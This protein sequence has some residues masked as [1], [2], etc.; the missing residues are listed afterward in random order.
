VVFAD[1][2]ALREYVCVGVLMMMVGRQAELRRWWMLLESGQV[3]SGG[4]HC[5]RR[6]EEVA[7]RMGGV[8]TR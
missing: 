6:A 3:R 7:G 8:A 5:W 2:R 4:E 1:L